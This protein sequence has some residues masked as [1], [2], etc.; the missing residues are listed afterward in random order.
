[1]CEEREAH[2]KEEVSYYWKPY[3]LLL[4]SYLV[5]WYTLWRAL[6]SNQPKNQRK[7][8]LSIKASPN[9]PSFAEQHIWRMRQ[10]AFVVF[11]FLF[12]CSLVVSAITQDPV[13]V[14]ITG[15]LLITTAHFIFPPNRGH[16]N[17][18]KP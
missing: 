1:M 8:M 16:N 3:L 7:T 13:F 2:K 15:G 4:F 11:V 18:Q 14:L 10:Q 12:L 6:M 5:K 17:R 9:K